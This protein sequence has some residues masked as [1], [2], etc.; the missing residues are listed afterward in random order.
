MTSPPRK[1]PP[2]NSRV[3]ARNSGEARAMRPGAGPD[4]AAATPVR[5]YGFDGGTPQLL[6]TLDAFEVGVTHGSNVAAGRFIGN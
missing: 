6:F 1:K 2:G 3:A 5:V 4:P